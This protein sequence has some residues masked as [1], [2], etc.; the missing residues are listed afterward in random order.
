MRRAVALAT[1]PRVR[2][3]PNPFVGAVL[4]DGSEVLA[5]GYHRK[6]GGAH[7]EVAALSQLK[8]RP[9]PAN[10]TL[11][12]T[13]EPCCTAGRTPPCTTAILSAGVKRVV[14]G[15]VDPNPLHRGRGL[16]LLRSAGV[17]V[18]AGVLGDECAALNK[19]FNKWIVTG[20]PWII[21][22][23]A[24]TLDGRIVLPARS[25]AWVSGEKSRADVHRLRQAVDVVIVGA[26]TA[27]ADDPLLTARRD[28]GRGAPFLR[29]PRRVVLR[30]CRTL[31]DS[32]R[33]FHDGLP[34]P[35]V[36]RGRPLLPALEEL[37][38]R[39]VQL[40]LLEGGGKTLGS[41]LDAGEID[42][43]VFFL[44]PSVA[45]GNGV[46]IAGTGAAGNDGAHRFEVQSWRR[47][48]DDVRCNAIARHSY[49][50]WH[51][52]CCKS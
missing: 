19:G 10:A 34:G 32:L 2:P 20:R 21:A 7:A 18:V 5:E 52:N 43:V 22:K 12:V 47:S 33:M 42:E 14:V 29:Q 38:R 25:G 23:A 9:A 36:L 11:Y 41:F 4:A 50:D 26:Q 40:A 24:L 45:G 6:A 13:L 35:W 46:A 39:G 30:G 31:P 16:D 48:G 17:E 28:G 49:Q 1:T 15:A 44:A 3:S 51:C 37:G 8:G 27:I